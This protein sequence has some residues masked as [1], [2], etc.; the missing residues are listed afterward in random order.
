MVCQLYATLQEMDRN[1]WYY[2]SELPHMFSNKLFLKQHTHEDTL[3]LVI[4]VHQIM[5]LPLHVP[6]YFSSPM[7]LSYYIY[8]RR[9]SS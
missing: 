9:S 1:M 6:K 8:T 7:L 2:T 3:R 4:D 5:M